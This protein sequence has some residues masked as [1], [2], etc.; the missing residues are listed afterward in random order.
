MSI[1]CLGYNFQIPR[2]HICHDDFNSIL[3]NFNGQ[4]EHII[5]NSDFIDM[6]IN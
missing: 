5:N 6:N 1:K 2:K 3:I 4:T